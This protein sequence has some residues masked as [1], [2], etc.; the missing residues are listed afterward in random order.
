MTVMWL[1]RLLMRLAEPLARGRMRALVDIGGLDVQVLGAQAVVV[2]G[3]GDCGLQGLG[4][5]LGSCAVGELQGLESALDLLA[6]NLVDDHADLAGSHA[7]I[8]GGRGD[9]DL[10][11][12]VCHFSPQPP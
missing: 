8:L 7:D 1:V 3:V 12:G 4:D 11:S 6:A 10:V 9:L 2:L 5:G